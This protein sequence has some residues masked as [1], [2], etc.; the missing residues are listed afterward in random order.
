MLTNPIYKGESRFNRTRWKTGEKKPEAEHIIVPV[1]PIIDAA[2]FEEV[3]AALKSRNP[4]VT[5][6]RVVTGPILLTGLATCATCGAGMTLRTGKSGRYRY[7]ACAAAAQKGK[8]ACK[9]RA[10]PMDKLDGI[11][12]ARLADELFTPERVESLLT[13]LMQRQAGR[14]EDNAGRMT[15]LR[16]K[17]AE[18]QV[19]LNRLYQAIESGIADPSDPT[20]KDR[21]AAIKSERDLAKVT[22]ERAAAE[23]NPAARIT[24]EKIAAFVEMMRANVLTG[25]IPFRRAY[26]RSVID[27]IEVDDT[28]IRIHGRRSVL[29]R[30]VQAGE[31]APAAVPSFVR[32][33]R[34]LGESNPSLHRER[35]AS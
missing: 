22:L 3:Q 21:V 27:R 11:V 10:V 25:E 14:E 35:V 7:Y 2:T 20:L 6:P 18:A 8:D 9:G 12:T 32:K 15:A 29:E 23:M 19:R 31:A 33:W 34:A 24:Q 28:E 1:E 26:I 5:P 16:A 4:R 17:L 30:L 13:G